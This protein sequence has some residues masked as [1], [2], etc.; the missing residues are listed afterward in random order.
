MSADAFVLDAS[1]LVAAALPN[2]P[3]HADAKALMQR[4]MAEQTSLYLPAVALAE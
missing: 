4:L 2:D 3:H 1:V